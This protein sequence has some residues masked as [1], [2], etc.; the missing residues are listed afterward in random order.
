MIQL[1]ILTG[2][3][4]GHSCVARRFPFQIGRASGAHLVLEEDGVWD[5]HAAI[6]FQRDDGFHL[7]SQ[8]GALVSVNGGRIERTRLHN[9]DLIECG[10][11]RIRFWLA[12]LPQKSLRPREALTWLALAALFALQIGLVYRL[13]G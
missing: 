13:V 10:S 12:A 11:T 6:H 2:R 1:V 8:I 9:G 7:E 5:R 4:A 3:K